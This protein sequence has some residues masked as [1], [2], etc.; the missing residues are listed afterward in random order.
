MMNTLDIAEGTTICKT[1]DRSN[2]G[3]G[4]SSLKISFSK[5]S[6]GVLK[7]KENI[8]LKTIWGVYHSPP[9]HLTEKVCLEKVHGVGKALN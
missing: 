9:H 4:G 2:G 7:C 3:G 5:N 1:T 8:K 6:T